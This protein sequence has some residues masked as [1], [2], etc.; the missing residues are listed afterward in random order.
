MRVET[1]AGTRFR[2]T[3]GD[4]GSPGPAAVGLDRSRLDPLLLDLAQAAGAEVRPGVGRSG[5][6]SGGTPAELAD[7][8]DGRGP[9]RRRRRRP[10]LGRRARCRRRPAPPLGDRPALTFH[11][12]GPGGRTTPRDA[13][14]IV[15][16]GGYVGLAPVPGGRVNVG[17]VLA[18]AR[19]G[20]RGS[21]ARARPRSPAP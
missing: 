8:V 17:I 4:D 20:G 5:A 13:R 14:M 15:F 12:A 3:Y 9:G 10:A 2:L 1:Q 19:R 18:V 11:V 7:G 21:R 6:P 16:D